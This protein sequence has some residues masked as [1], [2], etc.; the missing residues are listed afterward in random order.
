MKKLIIASLAVAMLFSL[1]T[2][3]YSAVI[4]TKEPTAGTTVYVAGNPDL[5]PLEYYDTKDEEYKGIVPGILRGISDSSGF[6]FSYVSGGKENEQERLAK[7]KQVEMVSVH[8]KGSVKELVSEIDLVTCRVN[9]EE[10]EICVGFTDIASPELIAAVSEGIKGLTAN[11]VLEISANSADRTMEDDFSLLF[12][13]PAAVFAVIAAALA[14]TL[15]VK[16]RRQKAAQRGTLIDPLTGIGNR[17]H[18]EEWFS[19]FITPV[20]TPLYYIAYIA[21]DVNR[22]AHY[23]DESA[24][25]EIQVFAASELAAASKETDFCARISDGVFAFGYLAPNE[26]EAEKSIGELVSKL[27]SFAVDVMSGQHISF[28]AGVYNLETPNTPCEKALF[29]ARHAYFHSVKNELDYAFADERLLNLNKYVETLQKKLW[30]A[31]NEREFSLY[32]QYIFDGRGKT[33][34]GA[35]SLSR[36]LNPEEGIIYPKDYIS[37]LEEAEMIDKLD[38]YILECCCVMLEKWSKTKKKNL[39]ISCN[40]TRITLS[41][42]KFIENFKEIV[43]KHKFNHSSLVLEFTEDSLEVANSPIVESINTCKKMGFRIALDDFGNGYSAVRDLAEYPIDIIKIDRRLVDGAKTDKGKVLLNSLIDLS[44]RL[45]IEALC[46][47]VESEEEL[48]ICRDAGCD[49]IQ[50][51]LLAKTVPAEETSTDRNIRFSK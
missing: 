7:N 50:G 18:F 1:V 33:A 25:S 40:M 32:L 2:G 49:Y 13:I 26:E 37:L 42:P 48:R 34:V 38:F 45:G 17:L 6:D 41:D 47:G 14:A 36:W 12:L 24:S 8:E 27:N 28:H 23:A 21:I 22:V 31:L 10:T 35:E 44:H 15:I 39:W 19:T 51:F 20:S 4:T 46:E 43:K 29:N 30:N 9:G 3:A 5:Y 16:K 11:D